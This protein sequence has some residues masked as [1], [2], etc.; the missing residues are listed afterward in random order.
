MTKHNIFLEALTI[1]AVMLFVCASQAVDPPRSCEVESVG[2][3]RKQGITTYMYGTHVLLNDDKQ[4]LYAL[5]SDPINLDLYIDKK[6]KVKGDLIKGYP[7]DSGP[8]YL[9]V[10]SIESF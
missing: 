6:V 5:K 3:I 1:V 8:N 4:T 2:I 7:V 10:K 9:N